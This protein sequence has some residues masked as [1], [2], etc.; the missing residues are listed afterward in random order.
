[1]TAGEILKFIGIA[2]GAYL[3]GCILMAYFVGKIF[4]RIDIREHGS[5]NAGFAN[6][7]RT[8]GWASA[9]PTLL[10]DVAKGV[11]AVWLAGL[12]AGNT[13]SYIAGVFVVAGHNWPFYLKF[14]GGK[15]I[16]T[17]LGVLIGLLPWWHT[18]GILAIFGI[19]LLITGYS[20]LASI[21]GSLFIPFSV[22]FIEYLPNPNTS[23][24]LI[25]LGVIAVMD[26]F[27]HR[28]NIGRLIKGVEKQASVGRRKK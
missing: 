4:D 15:G 12:I 14:K 27:Q 16:A 8:K 22:Y 26:V 6:M 7:L 19:V 2:I 25:A 11:V 21:L 28:E 3:I 10:G 18:I 24:L 13:A 20:S 5:G 17:T 9:V 23:G 1:M